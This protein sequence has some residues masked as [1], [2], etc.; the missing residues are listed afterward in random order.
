MGQKI[1]TNF[2]DVGFTLLLILI[3][4]FLIFIID[5]LVFGLLFILGGFVFTYDYSIHYLKI[6]YD[7]LN[8]FF[9]SNEPETKE[10]NKEKQPQIIERPHNGVL[11]TINSGR[12]TINNITFNKEESKKKLKA[13]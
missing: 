4:L 2:Y 8:H 7:F 10:R 1:R 5:K 3:G 12:D 13:K 11:Q 6:I 9:G